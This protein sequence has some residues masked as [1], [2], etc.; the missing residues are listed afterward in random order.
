LLDWEALDEL[1]RAGVEI[2]SHTRTHVALDTLSPGGMQS[3]IIGGTEILL[4]R[5]GHSP[6]AFAYPYGIAPADVSA[7]VR[8]RFA[9]GV[10][11][12]LAELRESDDR[13]LLPRLDAY[14][15]RRPDGLD[16]WGSARFRAYLRL[17][18]AARTARQCVGGRVRHPADDVSSRTLAA[19]VKSP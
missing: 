19:A 16:A 13:A 3:E 4:A 9:V 8:G 18:A 12:R 6:A 15:L 11:T 5:L 14:Y 1:A 10:T 2:G 7:L 17:R